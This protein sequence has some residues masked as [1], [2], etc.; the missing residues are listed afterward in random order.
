MATNINSL[1]IQDATSAGTAVYAGSELL[2]F[3]ISEMPPNTKIYVYCNGVNITS[4]CAP[5][6]SGAKI[7]DTI[8]TNS[9]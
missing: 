8:T 4:F 5:N 3:G 1:N 2:G 7:G 6:T 9:A